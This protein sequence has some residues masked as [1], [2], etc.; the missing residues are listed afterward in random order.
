MRE[1]RRTF[2][3]TGAGASAGA[4]LLPGSVRSQGY[5]VGVGRDPS[6]YAATRR[7]IAACGEWPVALAGRTVIVKPNLVLAQPASSGATTDPGVV[8]AVVDLALAGG[9]AEVLIVDTSPSGAHFDGC[10]YGYFESYDPLGRVRLADLQGFP[11][12][13]APVPGGLAYHSIDV[14]DVVLGEGVVFVS[15]AKLKV[16]KEAFVTL[17]TKNLFGL[18]AIDRYASVPPNGRFAMHDRGL[19]QAIVDINR[20]RPVHFAVV[21]GIWGMEGVG[22]LFGTPIRMDTVLAGR[23]P[24]A[25]DRVGVAA[26]GL[27]QWPARHLACAARFGLGPAGLDEIT[28]AGDPLAPRP[29]ALTALSPIIEYPRV[30][31]SSF[32]PRRGERAS[33]VVWYAERCL[34]SVEVVRLH[35]DRPDV[36]LVR[37]LLP[38]DYRDAGY[39]MASWDGRDGNGLLAA[40]GRYA[41]HLR[42]YGGRGQSRPADGVGWVT[43]AS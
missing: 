6:P 1:D 28:V 24:V 7:A 36:D 16:H 25:V 10:G 37:T 30:S 21:D 5:S 31:P 38:Y 20:V 39:E 35:D 3:R 4:L 22:P 18:P 8:Q 33:A 15:V 11:L 34:R 27:P 23:N 14:P 41:V 40:P 26:M 9:A 43:V 32:A 13:T 42:A 12:V 2:L 17:S 29:F 19:S